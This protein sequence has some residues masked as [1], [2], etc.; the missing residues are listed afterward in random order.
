MIRLS[1][2]EVRFQFRAQGKRLYNIDYLAPFDAVEVHGRDT[3]P[4]GVEVVHVYRV[5][6]RGPEG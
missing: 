4:G 2:Y 1:L 5:P 6:Q 3:Q